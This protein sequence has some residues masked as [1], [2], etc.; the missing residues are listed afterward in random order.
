MPHCDYCW[1]TVNNS[2]KC[3]C[4]YNLTCCANCCEICSNWKR[5]IKE[6]Q[7]VF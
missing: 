3:E 5:G 2:N 4:D 7:N 6:Q 1:V